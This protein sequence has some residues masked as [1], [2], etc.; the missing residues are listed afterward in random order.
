LPD[1]CPDSEMLAAYA[2]GNLTPEELSLIEAHLAVCANCRKT[3]VLVIRSEAIVPN[4]KNYEDQGGKE[5]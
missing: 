2:D 1:Q 4:D 5:D 3:I